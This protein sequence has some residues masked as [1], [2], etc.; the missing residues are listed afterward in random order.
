MN[1]LL[2]DLQALGPD[3]VAAVPASFPPPEEAASDPQVAALGPIPS[4]DGKAVL[5]FVIYTGD[6]DQATEHFDRDR[7]PP[8]RGVG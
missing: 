2:S 5:F 3:V 1:G 8:R 4:E 6:I 7:R